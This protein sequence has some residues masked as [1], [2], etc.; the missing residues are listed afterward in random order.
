[1]T[2]WRDYSSQVS[3]GYYRVWRVKYVGNG[4]YTIRCS[5]MPK[6]AVAVGEGREVTTKLNDVETES[7][8]TVP[9]EAL[10]H[11]KKDTTAGYTQYYTIQSRESMNRYLRGAGSIDEGEEIDS[12]T[13]TNDEYSNSCMRW[14]FKTYV[15]YSYAD[16]FIPTPST[17]VSIGNTV[18]NLIKPIVFSIECLKQDCTFES[19]DS[20]ILTVYQDGSAK[21][22]SKGWATVT[23]KSKYDADA[24]FTYNIGVVDIKK[25]AFVYV[26]NQSYTT[27]N[28][29]S[30]WVKSTFASQSDCRSITEH[31]IQT[32]M[33]DL[34]FWNT[35]RTAQSDLFVYRGKGGK[36][37]SGVSGQIDLG[38]SSTG[39]NSFTVQ[40][41]VSLRNT[42]GSNCLSYNK[43]A[44]LVASYSGFSSGTSDSL[45]AAI[46][47]ATGGSVVGFNGE[48]DESNADTWTKDFLLNYYSPGSSTIEASC[49]YASEKNAS[50]SLKFNNVVIK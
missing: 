28:A 3:I 40:D 50:A 33:T 38:V 43:L 30:S 36:E 32:S 23:V 9:D 15:D 6:L 4:Y 42:Y 5:Y 22:I 49:R 20:S 10:W 31:N 37:L 19:S 46:S 26:K 25:A 2:S 7:I 16:Y 48:I 34:A 17:R 47:K 1:M 8:S 12:F 13:W 24:F 39:S 35:M 14:N 27:Y 45:A 29:I 21:G 41:A 44:L 18:K 11:I